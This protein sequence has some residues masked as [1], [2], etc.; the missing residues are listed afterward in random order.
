MS[1][2]QGPMLLLCLIQRQGP[3]L[4]LCLIQLVFIF[5]LSLA[6]PSSSPRGGRCE[7]LADG[8]AALWIGLYFMPPVFGEIEELALRDDRPAKEG[9]RG[10]Y[11][12]ILISEVDP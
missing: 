12:A 2:R 11:A 1:G 7:P 5:S 4:L 9:A 8:H 6:A 10:V 3:M